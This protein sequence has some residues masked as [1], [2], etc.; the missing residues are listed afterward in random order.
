MT[1]NPKDVPYMN[2]TPRA[3]VT[4]PKC[5]NC[6]EKR[7]DHINDQCLL[8]PSTWRTDQ[9]TLIEVDGPAMIR[10]PDYKDRLPP[11]VKE[12]EA[13]P[14]DPMVALLKKAIRN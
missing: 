9:R 6:G 12:E 14:E 13:D 2:P 4:E 5:L 8:W 11:G 1:I 7:D 10:D 3:E